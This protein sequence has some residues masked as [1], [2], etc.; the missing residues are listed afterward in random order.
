MMRRGI[1]LTLVNILTHLNVKDMPVIG[2]LFSI[3]EIL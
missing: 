2:F 1:I 3:S